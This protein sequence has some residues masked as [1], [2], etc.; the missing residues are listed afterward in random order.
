MDNF[1]VNDAHTQSQSMHIHNYN[2]NNISYPELKQ[3]WCKFT[4]N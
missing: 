3:S 1:Y 4:K 2:S